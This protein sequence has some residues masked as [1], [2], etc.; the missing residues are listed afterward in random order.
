MN[1][2]EESVFLYAPRGDPSLSTFVYSSYHMCVSR[3]TCTF[4]TTPSKKKSLFL[5]VFLIYLFIC[6]WIKD[7]E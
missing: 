5:L 6:V 3:F 2:R 4:R 1:E 7:S